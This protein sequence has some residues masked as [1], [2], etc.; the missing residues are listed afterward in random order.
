M[1]TLSF[2][3]A[4]GTADEQRVYDLEAKLDAAQGELR[5]E[6]RRVKHYIDQTVALQ[7]RIDGIR[8]ITERASLP[9]I[10]ICKTKRAYSDEVPVISLTDLHVD[11]VVKEGTT[12]DGNVFDLEIAEAR[13]ESIVNQIVDKLK[14]AQLTNGQPLTIV[15]LGGDGMSGHIHD[16]LAETVSMHPINTARW[17]LDKYKSILA[18]FREELTSPRL[19]V[20]CSIGN[21]GRTTKERRYSTAWDTSYEAWVYYALRDLWQPDGI[22]F[23]MPPSYTATVDVAGKRLRFSHG[24]AVR[25]NGGIG[26]IAPG[27]A[28]WRKDADSIAPAAHDFI[29]HHHRAQ[30]LL[31][32]ICNGCLPGSTAYGAQFGKTASCQ[33][34]TTLRAQDVSK[35]LRFEVVYP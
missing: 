25:Y 35:L 29:G 30:Y 7:E 12:P 18:Y 19:V 2:D 1:K 28:R 3:E 33:V 23:V 21:H 22:E 17:L 4:A 34:L 15:H 32:T 16:E 24:E 27:L 26:G 10:K 5:A 8:A 13:L 11:E 6:R 31:N 9:P 14:A 20:V